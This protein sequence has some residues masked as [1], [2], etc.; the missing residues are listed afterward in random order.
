MPGGGVGSG[1]KPEVIIHDPETGRAVSVT[2][3]ITNHGATP[4]SGPSSR[5]TSTVM[6]PAAVIIIPAPALMM[7]LFHLVVRCLRCVAEHPPGCCGSDTRLMSPQALLSSKLP[8]R[9]FAT[10]HL[11]VPSFLTDYNHISHP[12]PHSPLSTASHLVE[13]HETFNLSSFAAL[14]RSYLQPLIYSP[15]LEF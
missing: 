11:T 13:R 10:D 15:T 8:V 6:P 9:T 2:Q 7:C 4:V 3:T 5:I 14:T 12:S 1:L